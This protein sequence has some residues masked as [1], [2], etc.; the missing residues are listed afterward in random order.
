MMC[1]VKN[2]YL[3]T[4]NQEIHGVNTRQN[5]ELHLILVRLTAFEVRVYFTGMKVFNHLAT[6]VKQQANKIKLFKSELKR[7][8]LLHRFIH[9]MNISIT[10][11]SKY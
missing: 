3:Y 7:Y 6:N 1:G 5:M 10:V 11:V 2:M 9:W 4:T 8:L